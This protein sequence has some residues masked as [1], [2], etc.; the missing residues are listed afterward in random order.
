[1]PGTRPGM[2]KVLRP[3][4]DLVAAGLV[5]AVPLV[6]IAVIQLR[7]LREAVARHHRVSLILP[8]RARGPRVGPWRRYGWLR[9]CRRAARL[10]VGEVG[11]RSL[12]FLPPELVENAHD[13]SPLF[14]RT[15]S[16]CADPITGAPSV[17]RRA[18]QE[19]E[20][21]R[22]Q[23][24]RAPVRS[25]SAN[26]LMSASPAT[27]PR[28]TGSARR[29]IGARDRADPA[30]ELQ[31]DPQARRPMGAGPPLPFS[32]PI[33]NFNGLCGEAPGGTT[34]D[35]NRI[36]STPSSACCPS[37]FRHDHVSA[38]RESRSRSRRNC[39]P[40]R[41]QRRRQCDGHVADRA[42]IWCGDRTV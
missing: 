29:L 17:P 16:Q 22:A 39:R 23:L 20:G 31:H 40:S 10:H 2:T 32:S 42:T 8:G 3:P 15:V 34:A 33:G 18:W 9:R 25:R 11:P 4:S 24:M 38:R 21:P 6:G 14:E 5:N 28:H 41:N 30:D 1:M 37:V 35:R 13:E 19:P 7:D 27:N 12:V 36:S 26:S